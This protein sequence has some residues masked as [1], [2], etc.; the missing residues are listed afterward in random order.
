M[1]A[2][3]EEDVQSENDGHVNIPEGN[4][5]SHKS[6]MSSGVVEKRLVLNKAKNSDKGKEKVGAK[7]VIKGKGK[8]SGLNATNHFAKVAVSTYD[9]RFKGEFSYDPEEFHYEDEDTSDSDY[10]LSYHEMVDSDYELHDEDDDVLFRAN[11]EGGGENVGEWDEMGY[12]GNISDGEGEDSEKFDSR[13]SSSSSSEDEVNLDAQGKKRKKKRFTKFREF[14]KETDVKKP[15]FELGMTF[16][17]PN[18]FKDAVRMLSVTTQKELRFGPNDKR[19]VRVIC[20]TTS[21]CP[22]I[23]WASQVDKA[24]PTMAIR[25]L[26]MEHCCSKITGKVIIAM[27]LSL[28]RVIWIR[29]WLIEIGLEREF[30]L[31]L[32]ETMG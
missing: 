12:E 11:V 20:K 5:A 10:E 18:A 21:G 4:D 30:K 3:I 31:L 8:G 16:P 13:K 24:S 14:N 27:L 15:Q 1:I 29:S 17:N 7:K 23:I 28:Q 9:T 32:V 6:G 26:K 2:D 22:F 19:R 25:T